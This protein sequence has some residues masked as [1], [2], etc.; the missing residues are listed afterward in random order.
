MVRCPTMPAWL[1]SSCV[2]HSAAPR[3]RS[4]STAAR[5]SQV[6][7]LSCPL[8]RAWAACCSTTQHRRRC[9]QGTPFGRLSEPACPR[10]GGGGVCFK[11]PG[12]GV[13]VGLAA[14]AHQDG[15]GIFHHAADQ[16]R[17]ARGRVACRYA[18]TAAQEI[19]RPGGAD[20]AG[21]NHCDMLDILPHAS[22]PLT[23]R[24]SL[25][26][27]THP[28]HAGRPGLAYSV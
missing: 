21:A 17:R 23:E 8:H 10:H 9:S 19:G 11:A 13:G 27:K 5:G 4:F 16:I 15:P 24:V 7:A 18:Q 2:A 12:I 28:G 25:T 6:A 1:S 20:S 22:F 26:R 14:Q 3:S